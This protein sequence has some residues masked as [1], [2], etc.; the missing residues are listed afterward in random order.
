MI[1]VVATVVVLG[2]LIFVHELGHFLLAKLFGVRVQAFSLGF[3]P[4]LLH[5]KIGDTEYRLSVVPL[6]GYV[7]L[8][9]EN[10]N[11]EVAPELEPYSFMHHPLWH[12]FLI[13]LA[14]PV[15]NLIFAVLA[16]FLVFA[17]SGI[18]YL[19]TEIGN[20][21]A[22]SPAAQAGLLA[23]DK[24]LSVAG[25]PVGRWED[26]SQKIRQAGEHPLTLSV[27]RGEQ[28]FDIEVL[29]QRMETS[30]I[31]G[32][33]VQAIIIGIS[34][35][36]KLAIDHVGPLEALREGSAYTFRLSW[37]TVLSFY[38]LLVREAPL[39]SLGGPILIAQV[40]GRQAELGL[41][42]LVQ[43]M[44]VLSVNLFLLNLLPIP[45]LDGGHLFF[46][47]LEALRGKPMATKHREVAQALGLMIILA[48]MVL[49][50]Y[51]DVVRLVNPQ[52]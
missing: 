44:A 45:V 31:F 9:G 2:I 1:T 7:K 6:G 42:Y 23:G 4:K 22:D 36:D 18:P 28:V 51:Q 48:L 25:Q 13:V 41:T 49:V 5:K 24:V 10:P 39:K 3:P 30:D 47:S 12:R 38:K 52:Y 46:F 19:T 20:V 32:A 40:A 33:K 37:L 29:P 11:D 50:F 21:K 27:Q 35:G 16:L 14:G 8:L 34:S 17:L 26:L 43:F 15:F